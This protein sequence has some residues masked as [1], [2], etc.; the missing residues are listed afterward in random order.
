MRL[1]LELPCRRNRGH[2]FQLLLLTFPNN[3]VQHFEC[4]CR[5]VMNDRKVTSYRILNEGKFN[6]YQ[7]FPF[8]RVRVSWI[9]SL[10]ACKSVA[11]M[12]HLILVRVIWRRFGGR[13]MMA[14]TSCL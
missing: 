4:V 10:P 9:V 7:C 5:I 13:W 12:F 8:P 14:L 6:C 1:S 3:T 2:K 11:E